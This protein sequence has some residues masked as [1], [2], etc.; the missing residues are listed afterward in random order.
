M[1]MGIGTDI[2]EIE[3]ITNILARPGDKFMQRVLTPA[4]QAEFLRLNHSAAYLAKR[5]AAKE[6]VAKALGTG[7]GHGVSFQDMNVV[8]DDRGAPAVELSGG[9]ND[10]MQGLGATKVLLSIADERHYAVAYA[11]LC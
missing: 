11:I 9:A 7:I 1:I 6:A 3:R 8:N 2:V 5:F 10:V 4:E